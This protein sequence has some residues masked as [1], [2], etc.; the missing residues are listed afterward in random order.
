MVLVGCGSSQKE[1]EP[2]P[3]PKTA[4]IDDTRPVIA[5]FGDSLSAGFGADPGKSYPDFLQKELD[6]RGLRYH[7]V[8]AGI[9]GDTSTDGLQRIDSVIA[10]KPVIVI[11]EFG[12]NDGLRGLP[13]AT[14]RA[15]LEQMI[16]A[17][18]KSDVTVVLAGMTLPPNYG[19]DY[20]KSFETVY[21]DLA[22]Q[23]RVAMV[24]FLLEGVG[25]NTRLMQRDGMHPTAEGNRLVAHN[26]LRVLLPILERPPASGRP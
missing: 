11:L 26:V 4:K 14:T 3:A 20:I 8:N 6:A 1:E 24:P 22:K 10:L 12:G 21:R 17:L 25:G 13:V 18:R 7:I 16:V 2:R 23:Y 5:A 9:S 19:P 15:N